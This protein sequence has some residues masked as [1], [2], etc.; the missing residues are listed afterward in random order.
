MAAANNLTA[1]ETVTVESAADRDLRTVVRSPDPQILWRVSSGRYV[2]RSTDAG[3]TWRAQWTSANAH[4][5]AGSAPSADT[6]WLVGRNGIVLVTADGKKWHTI[7]PPASAD[8]VA[9]SASN[10]AS[11]TIT[12]TDGRKFETSDGGKHWSPA[13]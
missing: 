3:A 11:A 7:E 12:S 1:N 4:V 10:A 8:F 6:C 2:E 13:P 9:V 5:V